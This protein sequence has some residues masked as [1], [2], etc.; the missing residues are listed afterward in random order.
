[1]AVRPPL[2]L[3]VKSLKNV[4]SE[5]FSYEMTKAQMMCMHLILPFWNTGGNNF[6]LH[7]RME[8]ILEKLA[9]F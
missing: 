8:S 4:Y 1:M 7:A 3:N 5:I 9:R 2:S 6:E